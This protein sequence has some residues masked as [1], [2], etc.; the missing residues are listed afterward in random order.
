MFPYSPGISDFKSHKVIPS[1]RESSLDKQ[2]GNL[3]DAISLFSSP[4]E[5]P[6]IVSKIHFKKCLL[7]R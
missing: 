1:L 3:H 5:S 6:Y 4:T 2:N 7:Q